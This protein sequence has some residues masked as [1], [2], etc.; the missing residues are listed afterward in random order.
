MIEP[1][2]PSI[3]EPTL[4]ADSF[5]SCSTSFPL[6]GSLLFASEDN[7]VTSPL[8][9]AVSMAEEKTVPSEHT[10]KFLLGGFGVSASLV[11]IVS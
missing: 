8:P 3:L 7:L 6:P 9:A 2:V 4:D 10:F 5:A 1:T 11:E